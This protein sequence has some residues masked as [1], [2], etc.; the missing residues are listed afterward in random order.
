MKLNP[1]RSSD[2]LLAIIIIVAIISVVAVVC[3]AIFTAQ[4]QPPA[5]PVAAQPAPDIVPPI[6]HVP[7]TPPP[8]DE[9]PIP[10]EPAPVID[11]KKNV[12]SVKLISVKVSEK[13]IR[14]LRKLIPFYVDIVLD[15]QS[16]G[17]DQ[18][19]DACSRLTILSDN[20][21][22]LKCSLK[23]GEK[24][25]VRL[26]LEIE[27]NISGK[28]VVSFGWKND[29]NNALQKIAGESV[30]LQERVSG[31]SHFFESRS[32]PKDEYES[33]NEFAKCVNDWMITNELQ[34]D[35]TKLTESERRNPQITLELFNT[36]I[37][38]KDKPSNPFNWF[39]GVL[40]VQPK[41]YYI[42][43]L[44]VFQQACL[45]YLEK[46]I[47]TDDPLI[48]YVKGMNH[49]I[50]EYYNTILRNDNSMI[51]GQGI[52]EIKNIDIL[53]E[54]RKFINTPVS[55]KKYSG[56][57]DLGYKHKEMLPTGESPK[58]NSSLRHKPIWIYN[59][60]RLN[61]NPS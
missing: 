12:S 59:D 23:D 46:S 37:R 8:V 43:Y 4:K 52:E 34:D 15:I 11:V 38:S 44:S 49:N 6:T 31:C 41:E 56:T 30:I 7:P 45:Y 55:S 60:N 5:P 22:I 9:P 20:F 35:N 17:N 54:K 29:S 2:N 39:L 28:Q 21:M 26:E 3:W 57:K 36:F 42:P 50:S 19:T 18:R 1:N 25:N 53:R 48:E 14:P 16:N 10:T 58:G 32:N 13:S 33:G 40:S 24:E 27:G 47:S 61:L 51:S